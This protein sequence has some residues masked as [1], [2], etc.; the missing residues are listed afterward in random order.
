MTYEPNLHHL[1]TFCAIVDEGG[2]AR[3]GDRL[4]ISQPAISAQ[5]KELQRRIGVPLFDRVGR[6]SVVNDAGRLA[7]EYARHLLRVTEELAATLQGLG[8]TMAGPVRVGTSPAWQHTLARAV[9]AFKRGHPQVQPFLEIATSGRIVERVVVYALDVGFVGEAPSVKELEVRHLGD[10][11]LVLLSAPDHRFAARRP[12][13][14]QEL[15]REVFVMRE[16]GS[17]VRRAGEASLS[18]LG[19]SPEVILEM[20]SD[21][22][23]KEAVRAG[24]GLGIASR[25]SVERDLLETRLGVANVPGFRCTV[26]LYSIRHRQRQLTAAQEALLEAVRAAARP[27]GGGGASPL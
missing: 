22:A 6:R 24:L 11:E 17:A 5:M 8:A 16:P 14:A 25:D 2:F 12:V 9:V 18:E 13:A 19:V 15:S 10:A 21:E 26:P 4:L 3:A 27:G 20:G 1:R 23:V 7:Y